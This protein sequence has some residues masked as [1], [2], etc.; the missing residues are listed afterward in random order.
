MRRT[1]IEKNIL[2][3]D[4]DNACLSLMA[5]SMAK[6]RRMPKIRI[7]SAGIRPGKIPPEVRRVLQEIGVEQSGSMTKSV[8]QVPSNEIDLV[9]SFEDAHEQCRSLPSKAKVEKWSIPNPMRARRREFRCIIGLSPR[10]R[11]NRQT[12]RRVIPGPLA[13]FSVI[14][15]TA[16]ANGC[17]PMNLYLMRHGI[18]VAADEPGISSDSARPLTPKGIKRI[19]RAA[20]GLRRLGISFDAILTSPLVR[21]RQTAE[22]V[23]DY[24][25]PGSPARGNFR[26]G[27]RKLCRSSHVRSH[28]FSGQE[29]SAPGRPQP[30]P[31]LCICVLNRW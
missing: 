23:A 13:P 29:A 1:K 22:I 25:W 7:F 21:A 31:G 11:R 18:A 30:P 2:F 28:S 24:P 14:V 19:R 16:F 17:G 4:E 3:L 9:V 8:D 12:H 6:H 10:Q 15:N 27:P 5:E 26:A 20:R